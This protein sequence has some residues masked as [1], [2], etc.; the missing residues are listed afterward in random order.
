MTTHDT[1]PATEICDPES[2]GHARRVFRNLEREYERMPIEE[3]IERLRASQ[4]DVCDRRTRS[5]TDN[6]YVVSKDW[7]DR[8]LRYVLAQERLLEL[9]SDDDEGSEDLEQAGTQTDA[10]A[11]EEGTKAAITKHLGT[12]LQALLRIDT[13]ASALQEED[14]D[15]PLRDILLE[16]LLEATE[17]GR[18]VLS[19]DLGRGSLL[20]MLAADGTYPN[21][22]ADYRRYRQALRAKKLK[23][24]A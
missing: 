20:T 5:E 23:N 17:V 11:F 18:S 9:L 24:C 19:G 6:R 13:V 4:F 21:S 7:T 1:E 2:L 3:C 12:V 10:P 15:S 16:E 22:G 8:G 14:R